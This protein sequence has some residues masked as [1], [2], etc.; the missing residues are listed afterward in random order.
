MKCSA[1]HF[2]ISVSVKRHFCS[3]SPRL[4]NKISDFA[5]VCKAFIGSNFLTMPF[6]FKQSGLVVSMQDQNSIN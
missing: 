4:W 2:S 6:A 1:V 3:R 5:N